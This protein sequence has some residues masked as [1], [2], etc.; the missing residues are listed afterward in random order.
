MA[1]ANLP[2]RKKFPPASFLAMAASLAAHP[3]AQQV[4]DSHIARTATTRFT[5]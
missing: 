1:S 3:E 2:W 4:S 5:G